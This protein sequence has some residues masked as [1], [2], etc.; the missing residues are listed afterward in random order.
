MEY[1][2]FVL[3]SLPLKK[4]DTYNHY[5]RKTENHFFNC[6]QLVATILAN[7]FFKNL[8]P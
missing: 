4:H 5:L 1:H 8:A 6:W 7:I 2:E 3:F